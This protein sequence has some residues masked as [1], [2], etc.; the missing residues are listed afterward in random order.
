MSVFGADPQFERDFVRV[1]NP[2][3]LSG[4]EEEINVA[5]PVCVLFSC[6][7]GVLGVLAFRSSGSR[8]EDLIKLALMRGEPWVASDREPQM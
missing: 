4:A 6:F 5:N 1:R 7:L 2:P 8:Q 3:V